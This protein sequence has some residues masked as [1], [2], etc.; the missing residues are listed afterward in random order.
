MVS[1]HD[2]HDLV[3]IV[4]FFA[5]RDEQAIIAA[6]GGRLQ[7]RC[8]RAELCESRTKVLRFHVP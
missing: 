5:S 1:V 4:V 3:L 2:T 6:A 7:K 8:D